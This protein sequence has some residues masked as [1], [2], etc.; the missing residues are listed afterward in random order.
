MQD[1]PYNFEEGIEH[2][3]LWCTEPLPSSVIEEK[4]AQRF[5]DKDAIYFVNPPQLQ[6]VLAVS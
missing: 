4:M 1:F 2:W 3:L 6:S 5:P